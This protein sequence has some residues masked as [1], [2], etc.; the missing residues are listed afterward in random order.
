MDMESVR[1]MH[2]ILLEVFADR[3]VIE[4]AHQLSTIME[5]DKVVVMEA[6]KIVE[7]GVPRELMR[8]EESV[9]RRLVE[10]GES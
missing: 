3:T 10:V 1:L 6:G 9:F 7:V 8:Y 2:R 4:I 5:F